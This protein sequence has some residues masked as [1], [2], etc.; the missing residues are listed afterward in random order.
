MFCYYRQTLFSMTETDTGRW[1]CP[2]VAPSQPKYGHRHRPACSLLRGTQPL[3]DMYLV[4]V[5]DPIHYIP[6]IGLCVSMGAMPTSR[7]TDSKHRFPFMVVVPLI[8]PSELTTRP[9]RRQNHQRVATIS[10]FTTNSI[11]SKPYFTPE[12]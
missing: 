9:R 10:E 4:W 5:R 7:I 3:N 8:S 11:C 1:W 6:P 2:A 12:R